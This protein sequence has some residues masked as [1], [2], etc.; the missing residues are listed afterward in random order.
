MLPIF[1]DWVSFSSLET[2]S[3]A[4]KSFIL[5]IYFKITTAYLIVI[6]LNWFKANLI[7][8]GRCLKT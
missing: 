8:I 2:K 7:D 1:K 3:K 6:G 4:A 5:T